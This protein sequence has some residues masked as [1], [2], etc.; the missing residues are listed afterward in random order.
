M[1]VWENRN[2][3]WQ[4]LRSKIQH[5]KLR[6]VFVIIRAT[7]FSSA[8]APNGHLSNPQALAAT[9]DDGTQWSSPVGPYFQ[10]LYLCSVY[11][12]H[13]TMCTFIMLAASNL[14]AIPKSTA[15]TSVY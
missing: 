1:D 13:T 2:P 12:H 10:A 9:I 6:I 11:V 4:V 8:R 5:E 3:P 15:K 7:I 14:A